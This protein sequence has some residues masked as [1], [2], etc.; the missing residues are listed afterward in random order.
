MLCS[1]I[2]TSIHC[3]PMFCRRYPLEP[4]LITPFRSAGEGTP[5]SKF[6]YIHAQTRNVVERKIGVLK[7]ELGVYWE[8]GSC[9]TCRKLQERLQMCV[10]LCTTYV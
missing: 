3:Y 5:E 2:K 10:Q 9:T 6:N 7:I 4:Y 8:Q 1:L